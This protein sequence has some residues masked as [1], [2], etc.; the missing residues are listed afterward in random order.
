MSRRTVEE[1]RIVVEATGASK[2]KRV[3]METAFR[4]STIAMLGISAAFLFTCCAP[5]SAF[6]GQGIASFDTNTTNTD[7]G[8]HPDLTAS[9]TLEDPGQP[10]AAE[11][12]AVNLPAGVFGNPNAI[13]P[14][15]P[16]DFARMECA[17]ASQAGYII[18]R[19]NHAG[20][21]NY[22]LGT[23]P[24]YVVTP[25]ADKEPARLAFYV[26]IINVAINIPIHI[27]TADDYGLRLTV[28]GIPQSVPLASAFIRVW[29]LPAAAA[30]DN[31]RF[32]PGSP[33]APAGCPG[34]L[35]PQ[36]ASKNGTIPHTGRDPDQTVDRQPQLSARAHCW[37]PPWR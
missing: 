2:G 21:P 15:I 9:F 25:R 19:A 10:E 34:Q 35:S 18:V 6:G 8:G 29:G 1:G 20:D 36:C 3:T 33:G 23:A 31:D 13:T 5:V 37:C 32:L 22:L 12:V 4:K 11:S 26:P 16:A 28:D 7:A 24:L 14:C 17:A 30:H 27:R